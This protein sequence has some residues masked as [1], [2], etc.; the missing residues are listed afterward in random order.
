MLSNIFCQETQDKVSMFLQQLV[1]PAVTAIGVCVGQMLGAIEFN[2][3]PHETATQSSLRHKA[4]IAGLL[5]TRA[6]RAVWQ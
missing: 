6:A 3:R 2:R 1:L 5:S 4:P